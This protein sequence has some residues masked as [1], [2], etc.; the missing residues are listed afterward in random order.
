[1]T[2]EHETL[3]RRVVVT[4]AGNLC[5]LGTN[6]SGVAAALR[7]GVGGVVPMPGWDAIDGLH[8]T[9]G[10][11]VTAPLLEHFSRKQR[12]SMGRVAQLAVQATEWALADAA[13]LDSARLR[14]G[15]LGVAYGSG[16][17][18]P[19]ALLEFV[20]LLRDSTVAQLKATSYLRAMAHTAAVN[21][22]VHYGITGRTLTTT[23]A[24]T[25][26]SQAIGFAFETI[27]SGQQ[28]IMLA[29]GAEELTPAHCAVFDVL[30]ATSR[31]D[32]R[33]PKPFDQTRDGLVLGEGASTLV[34]EALPTALA[35]GA[36][37]LGEVIGF[38]TNT[39]GSHVTQPNA[40]L[41]ARCLALALK[42]A[43]LAA[44]DID[45]VLA[46][47]T[48]TVTGD[49]SES[50]ATAQVLGRKPMVS[51]KGHMGHTLG[52]CGGLEAWAGL[53]M[54]REGWLAPTL[55]LTQPDPAC[56]ALDYVSGSPRTL[57]ARTF[58][59]NNFAFGGINTSLIFRRYEAPQETS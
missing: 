15:R 18:S 4:G 2:P 56:A 26:A 36:P 23:S 50:Q 32:A 45:F 29:G 30:L 43:G 1:M 51:L 12:R 6:W 24:C 40:A 57:T 10:A 31:S 11:P 5:A 20:S 21:I 39:D 47:G 44:A 25:A 58:M 41:Q 34:L 35:R 16:T 14:D 22:A 54:L 48:A 49:V 59:S 28:D 3:P 42:D 13:L 33:T 53:N 9:L 37:I 55:N 7:D 19:D 38:A 17:G 8:C 46:H 52:A 27:R